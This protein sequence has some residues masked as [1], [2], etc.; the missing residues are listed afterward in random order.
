M[1]RRALKFSARAEI[2]L[3]IRAGHSKRQISVEIG[4]DH[5]IMWRERN[6]NSTKT[7]GCK[8]VTADS[9]AQQRRRRPQV[10]K[11]DADGLPRPRVIADLFRS[12]TP[13]Q[14]AGRLRLEADEPSVEAMVKSADAHDWTVSHEAI[15]R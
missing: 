4:R 8:P 9:K 7:R 10:R 12:R 13:R 14:I 3:G 2:A 5:T 11:I 6:R 1:T 15:Y